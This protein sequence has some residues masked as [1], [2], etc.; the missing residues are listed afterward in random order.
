M[1]LQ[2]SK[3]DN[4]SE[5]AGDTGSTEKENAEGSSDEDEGTLVIDEKNERGGTKRKVEESAEVSIKL[6]AR[7]GLDSHSFS[8]LT[9]SPT[10]DRHPPNGQ[11]IRGQKVTATSP[12]RRPS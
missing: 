12:T 7:R 10:F 3:K 1:E 4:S 5:G 11:R 8:C 2:S 9:L 6:S